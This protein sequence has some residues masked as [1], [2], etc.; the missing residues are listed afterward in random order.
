MKITVELEV[1]DISE[2]LVMFEDFGELTSNNGDTLKAYRDYVLKSPIVHS[3]S[4]ERRYMIDIRQ[5]YLALAKEITEGIL[6]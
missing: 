3:P 6:Q 1:E 4:G 5:I 2:K